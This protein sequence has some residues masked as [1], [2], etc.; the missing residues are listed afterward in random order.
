MGCRGEVTDLG[1]SLVAAGSM[2][3]SR[4]RGPFART[5]RSAAARR[6]RRVADVRDAAILPI[7]CLAA[8]SRGEKSRAEA[9]PRGLSGPPVVRFMAVGDVP[10]A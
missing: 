6:C 5:F 4:R 10:A 2:C 8:S 3:G 1:R 9:A 7:E